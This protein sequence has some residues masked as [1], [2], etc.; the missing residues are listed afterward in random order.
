MSVIE[1]KSLRGRVTNQEALEERASKLFKVPTEL[2]VADFNKLSAVSKL[3]YPPPLVN[4]KH[5]LNKPV[6]AL[7]VKERYGILKD[8]EVANGIKLLFV[9]SLNVPAGE[10]RLEVQFFNRNYLETI[11]TKFDTE[12]PTDPH[13]ASRIFSISGGHRLPAGSA[14]GQVQVT[15]IEKS[16]DFDSPTSTK[17]TTLVLT[18]KPIGDYSTYTLS[19]NTNELPAKGPVVF[20]P[21]N[22]VIIDPLFNEIDFKFRPGCFN[23]NCAPDW[24]PGVQ[25]SDEPVIDYLAKDYD[26]FRHTMMTAMMRRVPDWQTSSEADLDQVLLDLFSA[27]A[28]ELSDYQDRVMNEA[29]LSSARKRVSLARHARLM[30]YHIHQGNQAS[31]WL[32]LEL[33]AAGPTEFDLLPGLQVWAGAG[34]KDDATSVVFV[35]R[36]DEPQHVHKLLNQLG[37]YTWGDSV[38]SLLAGDTTADL[39]LFL[40]GTPVTDKASAITVQ[41]L[42]REGK[43]ESLLIQEHLNPATGSINGFNQDKRQLLRLVAGANGA[44]AFYDPTTAPPGY[45]PVTDTPAGIAKWFVRV[46]WEEKDKLQNNYCFTVDSCPDL[47]KVDNVSLFHGN[48]VKV[49]HGRIQ[50]NVFKEPGTL[51]TAPNQFH[52]ERV[53]RWDLRDTRIGKWGTIC[54]LPGH[55]LAYRDTEPGG[56]VPPLSTLAVEV[57]PPGAGADAWDEVPSLIHS[58]DTDENGDHF[59]VETDEEGLSYIRFGNGRNGKEL[60]DGAEVRCTYQFGNGLEGNIG[61]DKL[62]KFA[63][64]TVVSQPAGGVLKRC[65]NPFD[66][67]NGRAPEPAAEIIRRAPEAYRVRQ[68][69]AVTIQDY[70]KR[71]EQLPE[72]SNATARYAWTGSWRTV[73]VTIDPVGTTT[74]EKSLREKITRHL[75]AVRLIGED[76]EIRPPRFVPVEI[77][78]SVCAYADFWPEDLK[79]I[80]EQEFSS[81]WTPD[82]RRGFFHPDLWTFGQ[83][84]KASQI[85][86]RVLQVEG[87]E[88]VVEVRMKRFN[89][90]VAFASEITNVNFDEILQVLN[91]PDHMEKGSIDFVVQGGRG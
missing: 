66:V 72:V 62:T 8:L 47:G 76:L 10:A 63:A 46:R 67:T 49:S 5:I 22:S 43:I 91:D 16:A 57:V 6:S 44:E 59:I 9:E 88:H 17:P 78:V 90:P 83:Q 84:L 56:D 87:I 28:D 11:I 73:Q 30:D 52:F 45:D 75:D 35:A 81:G 89:H 21:A 80:L 23:I 20:P 48:L 14:S 2:S 77:H 38:P 29:Y 64:A 68:L 12:H 40:N 60:A 36:N 39:Q 1:Q 24:K 33:D 79:A 71:A 3:L 54:A 61:R 7:T 70:V 42:I 37:L 19:V 82:G 13:I 86:G 25:P 4:G 15:K 34:E 74:L 69:R 58:D 32:A 85:I 55:P 31:T 65:W 27:A 50:T 53:G 18:V 26:S 51:L 41:Q